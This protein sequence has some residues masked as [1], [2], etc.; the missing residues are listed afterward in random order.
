MSFIHSA[1]LINL[2]LVDWGLRTIFC[3]RKNR[4][5]NEWA[6][7]LLHFHD[8][9]HLHLSTFPLGISPPSHGYRS[10]KATFYSPSI[11]HTRNLS[12]PAHHRLSELH[13]R[14][15]LLRRS[16]RLREHTHRLAWKPVLRDRV[17]GGPKWF[18]PPGAIVVRGEERTVG[19]R[20]A[21]IIRLQGIF[22]SGV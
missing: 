7:F 14:A 21:P 16:K 15:A 18:L 1:Y 11:F 19:V 6:S 8:T 5:P 2:F 13:I 10:D 9:G 17:R 4:T 12:S 3:M 22:V 20:E